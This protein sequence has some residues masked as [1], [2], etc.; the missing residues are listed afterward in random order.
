[1]LSIF[2]Q[3]WDRE[4]SVLR[5]SDHETINQAKQR[6]KRNGNSPNITHRKHRA[7]QSRS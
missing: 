6:E 1:M 2:R 4:Q 5:L 7:P 3:Q